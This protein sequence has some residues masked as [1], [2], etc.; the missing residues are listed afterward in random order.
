MEGL[1]SGG[2]LHQPLHSDYE[3]PARATAAG[4]RDATRLPETSFVDGQDRAVCAKVALHVAGAGDGGLLAV[5]LSLY[6]QPI[7]GFETPSALAKTQAVALK[8]EIESWASLSVGR[9]KV[10]RILTEGPLWSM[11]AC[12]SLPSHFSWMANSTPTSNN[13][14]RI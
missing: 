6:W 14:L 1:L 7:Y 3:P 13:L 11:D 9:K 8:P 12:A 5:D 4:R 10:S 2:Q